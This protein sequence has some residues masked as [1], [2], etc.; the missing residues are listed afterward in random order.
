[1]I[2]LVKPMFAGVFALALSM[3]GCPKKA[4]PEPIPLGRPR[5]QP[6]PQIGQPAPEIVGV[7]LEGEPM[8]LSD[9]RGK[10]VAVSFW[11]NW[12]RCC[13]ALFPHERQLVE[14][15]RDRPF[16]LLGVNADE[17]RSQ[18]KKVQDRHQLSW[19]SFHIGD[20]VGP[21]PTEWGVDAWPT[22]FVLDA[23]GTVRYRINGADAP[24]VERAIESLLIEATLK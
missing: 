4:P 7:D 22:I 24:A 5:V 10:V 3:P 20:A 9:F 2:N 17:N 8:K 1:M 19:R 15:Y 23:Q 21:V 14:K 6:G 13:V 12:C 11:A 18:A 16:V